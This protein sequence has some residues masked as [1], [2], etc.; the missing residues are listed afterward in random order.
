MFYNAFMAKAHT[1]SFRISEEEYLRFNEVLRRA[2]SRT[3][4]YAKETDVLRELVGFRPYKCVT[5]ADRLYL[6]GETRRK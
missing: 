3:L 6:S 1:L 4:D 2:K 5:E